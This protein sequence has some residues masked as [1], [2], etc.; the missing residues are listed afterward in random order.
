[1][2]SNEF[3]V[4]ISV[5]SPFSSR[6]TSSIN[7]GGCSTRRNHTPSRT[8]E[9]YLEPQDVPLFTSIYLYLSIYVY[10]YIYTPIYVFVDSIIASSCLPTCA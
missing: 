3:N 2:A 9:S 8:C 6:G 7:R 1:M 4:Y 5:S 10:I